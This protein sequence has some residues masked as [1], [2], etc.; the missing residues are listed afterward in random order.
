[1]VREV[2]SIK[3]MSVEALEEEMSGRGGRWFGESRVFRL[4]YVRILGDRL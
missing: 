2:A 3:G 4:W 1:V